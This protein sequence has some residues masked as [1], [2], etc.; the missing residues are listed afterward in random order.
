MISQPMYRV[1]RLSLTT[2]V[3]MAKANRLIKAKKREYIGSIDGTVWAWPCSSRTVA[4]CGGRPGWSWS[5]FG[6]PK[7]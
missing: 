3:N 6:C 4:P 1:S 5:P 2:R 7:L